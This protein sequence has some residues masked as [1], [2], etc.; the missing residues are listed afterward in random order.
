MSD[1]DDDDDD[2]LCD[3]IEAGDV[4]AVE[5]L[6]K[7]QPS[8]AGNARSESCPLHLA[9]YHNP[10]LIPTLLDLGV[11][12]DQADTSGGTVLMYAAANGETATVS[13]LL[14]RGADVNARNDGGETAFS[15]ACANDRFAAARLLHAAGADVNT[16]DAGGGSP[17]DWAA[18]WGSYD[19]YAWLVSVGARHVDGSP[20][21]PPGSEPPFKVDRGK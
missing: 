15:Y 20:P 4:P 19:F 10:Q 21:R 16:I 2:E 3:A 8:R 1:T 17:L 5:R 9:W 7:S 12:P 13:A 18:C 6:L 14:A 11:S